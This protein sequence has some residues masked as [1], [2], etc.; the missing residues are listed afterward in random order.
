MINKELLEKTIGYTLPNDLFVKIP[1]DSG[2]FPKQNEIVEK[3]KFY[4]DWGHALIRS[5]YAVFLY[6]IE[7]HT[8]TIDR[9]VSQTSNCCKYIEEQ[10]Y[11]KN[12]LSNFIPGNYGIGKW[13]YPEITS[14]IIVLLYAGHG[15]LAMCDFLL[16]YFN[17]FRS[18]SEP[19]YT[20][21]IENYAN[22]KNLQPRY[23]IDYICGYVNDGKYKCTIVV[24][25]EHAEALEIERR[26]ARI[27]AEK[28][29]IFA[30]KKNFQKKNFNHAV[31]KKQ[32]RIISDTR[33]KEIIETVKLIGLKGSYITFEQMDEIL[34]HKSFDSSINNSVLSEIG[35]HILK[36][37]K[38]EY[39]YN[40]CLLPSNEKKNE[41]N[42]NGIIYCLSDGYIKNLL[43]SSE[44]ISEVTDSRMKMDVFQSILACL[45]MNYA[46]RK[47]VTIF[48]YAK[49]YVF[50]FF[51][52]YDLIVKKDYSGFVKCITKFCG[53]NYSYD[54]F[55]N[56]NG[57][58]H[59]AISVKGS[60]WEEFGFGVS[61]IKKT[62]SD[63]AAEE[64][65]RKIPSHCHDNE[66]ISFFI[67]SMLELDS[68]LLANE[69]D[70]KNGKETKINGQ[71][72]NTDRTA[73]TI[74]TSPNKDTPAKEIR[75]EISFDTSEHILYI[76]KGIIACKKNNHI[77][78]P[79]TG[80]LISLNQ[81]PVKINVNYC[82]NCK[83]YFIGL[84]EY[85]RYQEQFGALLGNYSFQNI[86]FTRGKG[87]AQ[88][89]D[90]SPLHLC[91]YTVNQTDN[92]SP[93][94]RRLILENMMD[95]NILG[96][97]EIIN[98]LEFFIRSNKNQ[99]KKQSAV[100]KWTD[101][102]NWVRNFNINRQRKFLISQIKKAR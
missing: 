49:T 88:L 6:L 98:Y 61:E 55:N 22:S 57:I 70:V 41:L 62:A 65:L 18:D 85:K 10:V 7:G 45:W 34:I 16:P 15:F 71:I 3:N 37:L 63:Y 102:L 48:D 95:H 19:N 40:N 101:D 86:N 67:H 32:I 92:L 29:F 2:L 25:E 73:V 33:K 60:H 94:Q 44:K 20:M 13:S 51:D 84:D 69:A 83:Q 8:L 89:A 87:F 4:V 12:N 76:R 68:D 74:S 100:Q 93:R 38:Y 80:I 17:T 64:V 21:L 50:Q 97:P 42:E 43:K 96:K 39:Y 59:A 35:N 28:A 46:A 56:E 27:K 82:K 91:G 9:L 78:I 72:I 66:K 1:F 53:W 79:A 77:I 11:K 81:R 47:D 30:Y 23:K 26:K 14:K 58:I 90:E 52:I 75:E 24:G 5:A 99:S 31:R 36:L 54:D